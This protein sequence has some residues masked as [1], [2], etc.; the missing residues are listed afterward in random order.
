MVVGHHKLCLASRT[1]T[2][3]ITQMVGLLQVPRALTRLF[4]AFFP[5]SANLISAIAVL[6]RVHGA[7]QHLPLPRGACQGH[8]KDP[9]GNRLNRDRPETKKRRKERNSRLRTIAVSLCCLRG[10]E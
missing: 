6:Q 10:Y 2:H 7:R 3:N 9:T 1:H 8:R 4:A 5:L